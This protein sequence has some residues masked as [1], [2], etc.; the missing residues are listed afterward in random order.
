MTLQAALAS[1]DDEWS[2]LSPR[3]QRIIDAQ[4]QLAQITGNQGGTAIGTAATGGG[5]GGRRGGAAVA[6]AATPVA[7]TG[8]SPIATTLA[9]LVTALNDPNTPEDALKV[10]LQAFRDA[11]ARVQSDLNQAREELKTYVTLRQEAIL[12]GLGYLD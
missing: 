7:A 3:V 11:K 12:M 10:K 6:V 1:P 8:N 2:V 9:D 5:R 4:T